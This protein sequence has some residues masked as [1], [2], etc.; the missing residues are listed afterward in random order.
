[1]T[2]IL[3]NYHKC[4]DYSVESLL[5]KFIMKKLICLIKWNLILTIWALLKIIFQNK[6]RKNNKA[7]FW[8][9]L[10]EMKNFEC[11]F[12]NQTINIF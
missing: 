8:K 4:V 1:M 7:I 6:R 10:K 5:I 12:L 3:C 9:I 11:I 2:H